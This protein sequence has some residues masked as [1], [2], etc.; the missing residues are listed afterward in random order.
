MVSELRFAPHFTGHWGCKDGVHKMWFDSKEQV[1]QFIPPLMRPQE[2]IVELNKF[3]VED[4]AQ[5]ATE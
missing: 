3:R 5:Y 1:L 2:H 4:V